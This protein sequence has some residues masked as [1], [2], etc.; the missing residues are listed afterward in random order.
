MLPDCCGDPS[1][2]AFFSYYPI[3]EGNFGDSSKMYEYK[4]QLLY[5]KVKNVGKEAA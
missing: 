4:L 2:S 1:V 3:P 5:S